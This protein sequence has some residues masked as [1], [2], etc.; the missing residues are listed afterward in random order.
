MVLCWALL[1]SVACCDVVLCCIAS[2]LFG[3]ILL[4]R[5]MFFCGGS[6]C[7]AS[8]CVFSSVSLFCLVVLCCALVLIV[9]IGCVF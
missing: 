1:R 7:V 9:V 8:L 3:C 4:C 2:R 6:L 5:R